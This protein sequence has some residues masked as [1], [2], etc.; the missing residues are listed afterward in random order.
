M[1]TIGV[2]K[3]PGFETRVSLNPDI[4]AALVKS[5]IKVITEAGAGLRAFAT[6]GQ[7]IA[8]GAAIASRAELLAQ[9]DIL[10]AINAPSEEDCRKLK[11]GCVLVGVYQPLFN[12][13]LMQEWAASGL[14]IFSLDT[15]PR[16]TRAQA[17]DVLSSQANIAGYKAVLL[18]ATT[19]SR[20]FPMFMTGGRQHTTC[21]GTDS[22]CRCRGFAGHCDSKA[23]WRQ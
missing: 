10:L 1:L 4:A 16:T 19:Y 15:L 5:N 23:P 6:D 13:K 7:Y 14:T 22:R 12:Q 20:Y 9:S 11:P 8:A 18:A 2:L 17:M 3:E 21:Q